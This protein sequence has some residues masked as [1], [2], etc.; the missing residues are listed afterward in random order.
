MSENGRV[1]YW[2]LTTYEMERE[3]DFDPSL[4]IMT[5]LSDG[6]NFIVG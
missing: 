3:L 1:Y 4:S 5:L 6:K 2:N